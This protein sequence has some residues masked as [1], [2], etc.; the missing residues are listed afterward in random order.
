MAGSL[1]KYLHNNQFNA[2]PFQT[3][4]HRIK[5]GTIHFGR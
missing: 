2:Q 1:K 5:A 4:N 3:T